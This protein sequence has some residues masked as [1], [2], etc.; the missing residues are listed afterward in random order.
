[1]T[2]LPDAHAQIGAKLMDGLADFVGIERAEHRDPGSN[3]GVKVGA[4]RRASAAPH[5]KKR[6]LSLAR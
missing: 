4:G 2:L 6:S 5:S 3:D 1:V